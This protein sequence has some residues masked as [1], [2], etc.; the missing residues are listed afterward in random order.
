MPPKT[1]IISS[2]L[3][4]VI[5]VNIWEIQTFHEFSWQMLPIIS[6]FS[7]KI[8][9][10]KCWSIL[11]VYS[12]SFCS[13]GFWNLCCNCRVFKSLKVAGKGAHS[14]PK[15]S[16]LHLPPDWDFTSIWRVQSW[17]VS[18]GKDTIL[19]NHNPIFQLLFSIELSI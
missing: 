8:L 3:S 16:F 9:L 18:T 2:A 19:V 11:W 13:F 12:I 4:N 10:Y 15:L 17:G 7:L 6:H 1:N 14:A 5:Y